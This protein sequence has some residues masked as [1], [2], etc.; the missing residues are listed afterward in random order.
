MSFTMCMIKG[1]EK[2]AGDCFFLLMRLDVPKYPCFR[3]IQR[4]VWAGRCLCWFLCNHFPNLRRNM[5]G[6]A[7]KHCGIIWIVKSLR[8]SR[9]NDRSHINSDDLVACGIGC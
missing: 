6:P 1:M 8:V 9:D 4:L 2:D 7:P 3:N 5:G